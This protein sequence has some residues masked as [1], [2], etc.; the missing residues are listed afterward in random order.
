MYQ[1]NP[2]FLELPKAVWYGSLSNI[3]QFL[4]NITRIFLHFFTHKYF[5]KILITLLE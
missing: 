2:I 3:F 4:N 5:Q 1:I